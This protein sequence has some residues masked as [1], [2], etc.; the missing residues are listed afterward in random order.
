MATVTNSDI[1]ILSTVNF[2]YVLFF[3]SPDFAC[4][5]VAASA[6]VKQMDVRFVGRAQAKET[7]GTRDQVNTVQSYLYIF[8]LYEPTYEKGTLWFSGLCFFKCVYIVPCLGYRRVFLP[9]AFSRSLLHV[10]EQQ[11]LR[12]DCAYV[13]ARLRL[14]LA[15][16]V[17]STIFLMCWLIVIMSRIHKLLNRH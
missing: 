3:S 15:S 10:F 4:A 12:R 17:I 16:Y 13:Q 7:T 6:M 1:H 8:C 5:M 11:S 9:E 14:L 2:L